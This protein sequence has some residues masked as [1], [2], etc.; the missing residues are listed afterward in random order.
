MG[1]QARDSDAVEVIRLKHTEFVAEIRSQLKA[2]RIQ[3]YNIQSDEL[4]GQYL[5]IRT[6]EFHHIRRQSINVD[7]ISMIWNGL[8]V[9]K[10]THALITSRNVSDEYDLISLCQEM[11]W[12][13]SWFHPYQQKI[14]DFGF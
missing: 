12:N 5:N 13:E 6:A 2:K 9:N 14:L 7:L 10:D 8:I 3:Q 4:T 11:G 1:Q